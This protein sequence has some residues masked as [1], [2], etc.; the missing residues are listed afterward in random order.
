MAESSLRKPRWY[1]IPLRVLL[2]TVVVTLLSFAVS[3]LLGILGVILAAKLKGGHAN[4]TLAYR[5]VA[6]PVA[7]MVGTIVL[8]SALVMEIRHYR[9]AKALGQ[10]ADQMH[11]AR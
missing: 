3:L 8:I 7:A 11:P 10:I 5:D 2:V 1:L 6:L 4:M 9:Q